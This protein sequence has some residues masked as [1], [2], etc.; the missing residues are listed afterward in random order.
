MNKIHNIAKIALLSLMVCSSLKAVAPEGAGAGVQLNG[1]PTSMNSMSEPPVAALPGVAMGVGTIV[2]V[3]KL[4]AAAT[5][6]VADL[7]N[8]AA[9]AVNAVSN[10]VDAV[11]EQFSYGGG[12]S[13]SLTDEIIEVRK[14]ILLD[15]LG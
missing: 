9:D 2:A 4:S 8:A 12:E 7:T 15:E 11:A 6:A 13:M 10:L 5:N 14:E 1:A 3:T